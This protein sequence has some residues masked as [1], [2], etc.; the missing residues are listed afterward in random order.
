MERTE[1]RTA[2]LRGAVLVAACLELVTWLPFLPGL[3]VEDWSGYTRG[4]LAYMIFLLA[5]CPLLAIAGLTLAIK[6]QRIG[7]AAILVSIQPI[8]F[9]I[10]V[11]A[12]AVGVFKYGF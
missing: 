1:N 9:V 3:L 12:F 7:L 8:A 6:N 2:M 10:S 11:V 4:A 5:V